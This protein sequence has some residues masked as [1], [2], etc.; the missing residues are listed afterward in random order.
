MRNR[1]RNRIRIRISI[2]IRIRGKI[3]KG[4]GTVKIQFVES[5]LVIESSFHSEQ[6][7]NNTNGYC[8]CIA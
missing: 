8:S 6:L 7:M 1:N 4:K 2:R 5:A 3:I